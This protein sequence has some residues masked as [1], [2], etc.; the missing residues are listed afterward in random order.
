MFLGECVYLKRNVDEK[1]KRLLLDFNRECV[2]ASKDD[3]SSRLD[4]VECT[5]SDPVDSEERPSGQ[6]TY[7]RRDLR[8]MRVERLFVGP[9]YPTEKKR[10]DAKF[11]W[12]KYF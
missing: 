12:N 3:Q 9:R 7:D 5:V 8:I 10:P 4:D 1:H 11:V 6:E 2:R